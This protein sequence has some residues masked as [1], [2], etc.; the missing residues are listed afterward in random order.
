[1]SG[2]NRAIPSPYQ[3][4]RVAG[5][6]ALSIWQHVEMSWLLDCDGVV[7]LGDEV[8]PGGAG[9][10][11][12]LRKAG[13]RVV[14]LTN[15]SWPRREEQA[16]K[17]ESMGIPTSEEDV[18][19]SAMSVSRLVEPGEVVLVLGGPGVHEELARAGAVVLEPGV[20]STEDATAVVVGMDAAFDY[21]RLSAATAVL[22]RG[23]AR[24]IATN[25]DATFPT[26][27][28]LLPGAGSLLAAVEVA[29][30]VRA[31]VAGKPYEPVVS[32]LGDLVGDIEIVVGDRPSTDGRLAYSLGVPFG[33]VFSGVTPEVHGELDPTPHYEAKDLATLV[34]D[35]LG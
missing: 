26:T 27:G 32:L 22:R 31:I 17:L 20:D 1:M 2:E 16:R 14:F 8:V 11:E 25:D 33:L 28:G 18:V 9:A 34:S 13:K 3:S 30:G 15:N 24:L 35:L 6:R 7:W 12:R 21:K 29:G 23:Q 4:S 10:V 19:T 5:N